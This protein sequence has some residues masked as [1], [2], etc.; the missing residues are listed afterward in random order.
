[1]ISKSKIWRRFFTRF[2]A[3]VRLDLG[4][5]LYVR[6]NLTKGALCLTEYEKRTQKSSAELITHMVLFWSYNLFC[7]WNWYFDSEKSTES[8]KLFILKELI[9]R[10]LS[11]FTLSKMFRFDVYIFRFDVYIF[12]FDVYIF[13]F[14]EYIFQLDVYIFRFDVYIFRFLCIHLPFWCIHLP[15]WC[16]NVPIWCIHL[17]IW[18]IHLSIWCIHLP[19]WCTH[20]PIWCEYLPIWFIFY[21]F[22]ISNKNIQSNACHRN[23]FSIKRKC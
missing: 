10:K 1:M 2:R 21:L 11:L 9:L 15:I 6:L 13:R 23:S 12:R 22:N 19:I 3:S 20:L 4:D 18:C 16:I 14:D 5:T 7:S 17:P 8:K